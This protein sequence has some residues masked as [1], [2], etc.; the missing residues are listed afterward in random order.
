MYK[1][2]DTGKHENYRPISVLPIFYKIP[3]KAAHGQLSSIPEDNK[4][5]TNSQFGYRQNS[6]TKFDSTL[7]FDDIRDYIDQG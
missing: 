5:L 7:L 2:G 4:L 6:S 3:E 1:S